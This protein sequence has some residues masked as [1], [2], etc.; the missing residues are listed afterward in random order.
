M[1]YLRTGL[2]LSATL[3]LSAISLPPA[4]AQGAPGL[5][6]TF[7]FS[8]GF[9]LSDNEDLDSTTSGATFTSR[10]GLGFGVQSQTRAETLQLQIGTQ[11]VGQYG[12]GASDS[13]DIENTN[14]AFDYTRTGASARL[15]FSAQYSEVDL[16][17][18]VIT[19]GPTSG[20]TGT[21]VIDDGTAD[22]T[23][24]NVTLE[25]G[26]NEPFGLRLSTGYFNEDFSGTTDPSLVDNERINVDALASFRL[27]PSRTV[28]VLAGYATTDEIGVLNDTDDYYLGLGIS[29]Q[30]R[31]QLT[32]SGDII[33]D[34][35][36]TNGAVT[37]DGLGFDVAVT[38]ARPDG[39]VGANLTSR[40]SDDGRRTQATVNRSFL[41][42][43]GDLS[44][45]L[46]IV[47]QEGDSSLRPS[48]SIAY[49]RNTPRGDLT[50]SL[51]Q[52]PSI[53]AGTIYSNTSIAVGYT[54]QINA[55]SGW[56]AALS[57]DAANQLGSSLDDSRA[58][59]RITY[60]RNLTPEWQMN[61]GFQHVREISDGG[62]VE[63]SNTVFFNVQRD[64]AFGF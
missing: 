50:A 53:D 52:D 41:L 15:S 28:R 13:F 11:V 44:F 56:S 34:R 31:G 37:N 51:S 43:T 26:I 33:Y 30:T 5:S 39:S 63:S 24:L 7:T 47:D 14:A 59:A 64:I 1:T 29:G 23:T 17:D 27:N 16:G 62:P 58:T 4:F 32:Y 45:A 8:Q 48:G 20:G 57:Y 19:L 60:S 3:A 12:G 40:T 36:E 9:E 54:E 55:T 42:P 18:S 46:G 49:T 6:G 2:S 10:T 35:S 21:L 61:T 25:T 22:I 38:Q